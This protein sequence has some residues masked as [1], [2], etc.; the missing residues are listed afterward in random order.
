MEENFELSQQYSGQQSNNN[1]SPPMSFSTLSGGAESTENFVVTPQ[2]Y[3]NI[4]DLRSINEISQKYRHIFSPYPSFNIVQ[5]KVLDDVFYSDEPVVVSAPTGSGKTAIFEM[6]IIRLLAKVEELKYSGDFK[7][8]YMAPVKALCTERYN[9]WQVKFARHGLPCQEL[10]GDTWETDLSEAGTSRLLLTTPE[11]WDSLTRRWRDK[12]RMVQVVKLFLID[13]VGSAP[14]PASEGVPTESR[15]F[16]NSSE[17]SETSG[18]KEKCD[19]GEEVW[20]NP[21]KASICQRKS[22]NARSRFFREFLMPPRTEPTTLSSVHLLNE[23]KRGPILEVVVSRMKTV[24]K[25]LNFEQKSSSQL[26]L[27][28]RFIAVS[29][30]IPNI[31]DI[32]Q[33]LGS[34][35]TPAR[36]HKVGD[37]LR[38]VKLNKVVMGYSFSSSSAFQFDICLSYKLRQLLLR[39]AESKPTLIFCSTRK[40]VE[41]TSTT[42][43]QQ[44]TVN[45]SPEQKE[46]LLSAARTLLEGKLRELIPVGV[47]F[48]HAGMDP[49]DR[50]AVECLFR[51]GLLPILVTTS[52]LAMGVNLP[53][54]LV[55]IKSTQQYVAGE[56]REYSETQVLQM[57][58]RA[59]RPQFDTA[60]TA[61]IMTREVTRAKYEKLVEGKELVESSLH[62][63]L[64]E[65][66]NAEVVL[67]TICELSV[68]MDWIRST[69]LY[70]RVMRNPRHYGF[71]CHVERRGIERRLE[72]LC[73]REL[74]ELSH[75]KLITLNVYDVSPTEMGRLMARYYIAFES[76]K[77]FGQICGTESL[78]EMLELVSRCREFQD[79]QLRVNEKR[80]LNALNDNKKKE[81]I[82]FPLQGNIKTRE[83]KVN[84]LAQAVFGC[85]PVPDISLSQDMMKIVRIGERLV[86]CLLQLK[87]VRQHFSSLLSTLLLSKCFR[88]R[89]WENSP[90]VSRQFD[91]IGPNLSA[92]LVAAGKT[93]FQALAEANPRDLERIL[94]KPPPIGNRI[95]EMAKRMPNCSLDLQTTKSRP[96]D[97]LTVTVE[98]LNPS[99][100]SSEQSGQSSHVFIL[101]VGDSKN[102][103]LLHKKITQHELV[104]SNALSWT[105]AMQNMAEFVQAHLIDENW[106]GLD[107]SKKIQLMNTKHIQ[108]TITNNLNKYF[109]QSQMQSSSQLSA[110]KTRPA[111]ATPKAKINSITTKTKPATATPKPNTS[112]IVELLKKKQSMMKPMPHLTLK[113]QIPK[114]LSQIKVSQFQYSPKLKNKLQPIKNTNLTQQ[115]LHQQKENSPIKSTAKAQ[116]NVYTETKTSELK[117][118]LTVRREVPQTN[119]N[120]SLLKSGSEENT[121]LVGNHEKEVTLASKNVSERTNEM[122]KKHNVFRIQDEQCYTFM[123]TNHIIDKQNTQT[124]DEVGHNILETMDT[125][126]ASQH[127]NTNC[128]DMISNEAENS[129]SDW[130][131]SEIK[132]ISVTKPQYIS[133]NNTIISAVVNTNQITLIK[134]SNDFNSSQHSKKKQFSVV[135]QNTNQSEETKMV[136]VPRSS[137]NTDSNHLTNEIANSNVNSNEHKNNQPKIEIPT[138]VPSAL[139][140][141]SESNEGKIAINFSGPLINFDLGIDRLLDRNFLTDESD[142]E[143]E[144]KTCTAQVVLENK[145][146]VDEQNNHCG[147]GKVKKNIKHKDD[148]IA[149]ALKDAPFLNSSSSSSNSPVAEDILEG[150]PPES[151]W[152]RSSFLAYFGRNPAH[153]GSCNADQRAPDTELR[154]ISLAKS[155]EEQLLS[156]DLFITPRGDDPAARGCDSGSSCDSCRNTSL[157]ANSRVQ[158]TS[159]FS[160]ILEPHARNSPASSQNTATC[161]SFTPFSPLWV[162]QRNTSA[163]GLVTD[164]YPAAKR[165]RLSPN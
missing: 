68:A 63:H 56:Y 117:E 41:H 45:F 48:H 55:V 115:C 34:E 104:G 64:P 72:E 83:M 128:N 148:I 27:Y 90:Y 14:T 69:F 46:Q 113:N 144:S 106:I 24:Q 21:S 145:H 94:N 158:F 146:Q 33:W 127:H 66:L 38:P 73:L 22:T 44:L 76:M 82:R 96:W 119:A 16:R 42:L 74:H 100:V 159:Q 85:L 154:N 102:S 29:A 77:T 160:P 9:D 13:E 151:R 75:A 19:I 11:K 114:T 39:Y 92:L 109:T 89:L 134:V 149:Q 52:T 35:M 7:I 51:Q 53:A 143:N 136:N 28:I 37:E 12:E 147:P 71:P 67:K 91:R 57:I 43:A 62:R 79:I 157:Q 123:N 97:Q 129:W 150:A 107:A 8:V 99:E 80:T 87:Q 103:I 164:Y 78:S 105:M 23:E 59:G 30:T 58:G 32:A 110:A 17:S 161:S 10:T 141:A 50:Q 142:D 36:Q 121:I 3:L 61:V 139:P 84:C 155:S 165:C 95:Q 1:E 5:S 108:Q 15:K 81:G 163:A 135:L 54:H 133:N 18:S 137:T 20:T 130:E 132:S 25:T 125:G 122:P 31:E 93:S 88:R 112:S 6:A 138:I 140:F 49:G 70:V 86:K 116:Y 153:N 131:T 60:A 152:G 2:N 124:D 47:G 118:S 156:Q 126:Y 101:L 40:S 111:T 98:L 4:G 65:H 120:T 26:S 162:S